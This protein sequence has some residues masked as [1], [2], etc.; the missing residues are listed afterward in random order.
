V[1]AVLDASALLAYLQDEPGSDT[2]KAVLRDASISSVNWA[3]IIQKALASDVDITG[4][5]ADLEALGVRLEPFTPEQAEVAGK[6]WQHTRA[7][8]L[9]LGDRA[10]LALALERGEPAYTTDSAWRRLDLGLTIETVR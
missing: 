10:C 8:G 2:V 1:S 6:L 4:L 5:R 9:S 3:E 7:L